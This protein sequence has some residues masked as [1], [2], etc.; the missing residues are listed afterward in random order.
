MAYL[1]GR[2]ERDGRRGGERNQRPIGEPGMVTQPTPDDLNA[3]PRHDIDYNATDG[4]HNREAGL[5]PW[6]SIDERSGIV[7]DSDWE[8]PVG[9]F[10]DGP[11]VWRQT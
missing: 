11:G 4:R 9:R 10:P 8:N 2:D 7:T 1:R 6:H 5:A 3:E